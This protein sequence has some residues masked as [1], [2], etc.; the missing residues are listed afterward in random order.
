MTLQESLTQQAQFIREEAISKI[1]PG[2]N[3]GATTRGESKAKGRSKSI[4]RIR[5]T[6]LGILLIGLGLYAMVSLVIEVIEDLPRVTDDE[7]YSWAFESK[8]DVIVREY[9]PFYWGVLLTFGISPV[10]GGVLFLRRVFQKEET[11]SRARLHTPKNIV[12]ATF[13]GGPL[14]GGYLISRNFRALGNDDAGEHSLLIAIIA[15]VVIFGN[16][17]FLLP[18]QFQLLSIHVVSAAIVFYIVRSYQGQQI[19]EHLE[20]GDQKAPCGRLLGW[21]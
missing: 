10:V 12:A 20:K 6:A 7:L 19:K 16:L 2:S 13:L 5:G 21:A 18:E 1:R 11:N 3:V 15:A 8:Q 14:A 4:R 17:P 9:L